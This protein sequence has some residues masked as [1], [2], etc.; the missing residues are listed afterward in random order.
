M[1]QSVPKVTHF[2]ICVQFYFK[3]IDSYDQKAL[4][5][6]IL[7]NPDILSDIYDALKMSLIFN[8][9]NNIFMTF[10]ILMI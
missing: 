10:I 7:P 6:F 9:Q 5:K 8:N 3:D 2:P 1:M 4:E